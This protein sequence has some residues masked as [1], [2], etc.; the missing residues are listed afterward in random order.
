M[1]PAMASAAATA[2]LRSIAGTFRTT[3]DQPDGR[4]SG[5]SAVCAARQDDKPRGGVRARPPGGQCLLATVSGSDRV[6]W[7]L[8]LR[9][10][11]V[12]ERA[13]FFA[14]PGLDEGAE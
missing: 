3:G 11:Q 8:V 4:P 12:G 6:W 5:R 7:R 1:A 9:G 10:G 2:K 14:G 13:A